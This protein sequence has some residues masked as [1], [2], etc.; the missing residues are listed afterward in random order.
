MAQF[1]HHTMQ[2]RDTCRQ[3]LSSLPRWL[4][5]VGAGALAVAVT[6][7]A[8]AAEPEQ[9]PRRASPL[10]PAAIAARPFD[11]GGEAYVDQVIPAGRLPPP[12]PLVVERPDGVREWEIESRVSWQQGPLPGALLA[13]DL[14]SQR[15]GQRWVSS[16][17]AEWRRETFNF[18]EWRAVGAFADRTGALLD[19]S[20]V[21]R[22]GARVTTSGW[23]RL[24]NRGFPV[25]PSILADFAVGDILFLPPNAL[26]EPAFRQ[27]STMYS[28]LRGVSASLRSTDGTWLS[29]AGVAA[30]GSRIGDEGGGYVRT[31]GDAAWLTGAWRCQT[32]I[33][34]CAVSMALMRLNGI[35]TSATVAGTVGRDAATPDAGSGAHQVSSAQV[36]ASYGNYGELTTGNPWAVRFSAAASA[37]DRSD[38][39]AQR[40]ATGIGLAA[41]WRI[42]SFQHEANVF[43]NGAGLRLTDGPA[44]ARQWAGGWSVSHA[45]ARANWGVGVDAGQIWSVDM[46]EPGV[47]SRVAVRADGSLRLGREDALFGG[48][49]AAIE[50]GSAYRTALEAANT[51]F[52]EPRVRHTLSATLGYR[53]ALRGVGLSSVSAAFHEN[54]AMV[55]NAP[56]ASGW[57]LRWNHD[58]YAYQRAMAPV[59]ISTALGVA[60]D[61]QN[62]SARAYPTGSVS[63]RS[64]SPSAVSWD[65]GLR[66]DGARGGQSQQDG[67]SAA[68]SVA[69]RMF[70]GWAAG[71]TVSVNEVRFEDI[72]A[73]TNGATSPS[74]LALPYRRHDRMATLWLRYVGRSGAPFVPTGVVHRYIAGGGSITG[75]V[76]FDPNR[77]S[78]DGCVGHGT[79]RDKERNKDK[80][81]AAVR[82]VGG[83]D[84]WIDGRYGTRTDPDGRFSFPL[85]PVG[86]HQLRLAIESIPLPYEP[87]ITDRV[88]ID[89]A[90]RET[91]RVEFQLAR[92]SEC[93]GGDNVR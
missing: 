78:T 34:P 13:P 71:V 46:K 51:T 66:Y 7:G 60:R 29:T 92:I 4:P 49:S 1:A 54:E 9:V 67:F 89:V 80:A 81:D 83:L 69:W 44:L 79:H 33:A 16:V 93:D 30:L 61:R 39:V 90:L 57:Q 28:A 74:M 12:P 86:S 20:A 18:G 64:Q 40:A 82:G 45:R 72:L 88:Q 2:A 52:A 42:G 77:E 26:A 32:Q 38:L 25:V 85:V 59:L 91:A 70:P 21:T 87:A 31:S 6:A 5:R 48:V 58:W 76:T 23:F 68:G 53:V 84:I 41:R 11:T 47:S 27:Q 19:G 37:S 3:R 63:A 65:V 35:P 62:G 10:P 14:P 24:E 22:D 75:R 15:S 8:F 17:R 55:N 36:R 73:S 50:R 43:G 56:R